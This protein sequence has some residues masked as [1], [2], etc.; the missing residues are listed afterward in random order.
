MKISENNVNILFFIT[1]SKI[2]IK[3][4]NKPK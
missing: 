2:R 3:G 1:Q 4:Y